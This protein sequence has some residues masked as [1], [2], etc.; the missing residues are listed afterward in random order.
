[1][2]PDLLATKRTTLLARQADLTRQRHEAAGAIAVLDELLLEAHAASLGK[3]YNW[4]TETRRDAPL[5]L[6]ESADHVPESAF[7]AEPETGMPPPAPHVMQPVSYD[8][9]PALPATWP[10]SAM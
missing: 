10:A 6:V 9:D 8:A 2:T 7:D 4:L 1:M 5:T 3:F